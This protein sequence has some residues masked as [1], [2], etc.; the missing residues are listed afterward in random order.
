MKSVVLI[1]IE[2]STRSRI[3]TA[4]AMISKVVGSGNADTVRQLCAAG[5]RELDRGTTVVLEDF[6]PCA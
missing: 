2:P 3:T 1:E 4:L 5:Q 6:P